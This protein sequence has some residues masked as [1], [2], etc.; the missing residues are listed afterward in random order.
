MTVHW[1]LAVTV[2]VSV[3]SAPACS[4]VSVTA[5]GA[6][7]SVSSP[8]E[9]CAVWLSVYSNRFALR[10]HTSPASATVSATR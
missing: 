8:P 10:F 9:V 4:A 2:A 7:V 1:R 6:M 3:P 5:L